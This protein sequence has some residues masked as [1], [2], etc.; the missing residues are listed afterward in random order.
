MNIITIENLQRIS[1]RQYADREFLPEAYSY[2]NEKL[3]DAYQNYHNLDVSDL[4]SFIYQSLQDYPYLGDIFTGL[5]KIGNSNYIISKIFEYIINIIMEN[6]RTIT[7]KIVTPFDVNTAITMNKFTALVIGI[8]KTIPVVVSLHNDITTI[9]MDYELYMGIIFGTFQSSDIKIMISKTV[10]NKNK[11]T[12]I[13]SLGNRYKVLLVEINRYMTFNN[14]SFIR[15]LNTAAKWQE[16]NSTS[17]WTNLKDNL[18]QTELIAT[19]CD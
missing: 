17:I 11:Y 9:Y 10:V 6:I 5:V 4:H 3:S 2:L 16:I 12:E 18:T 1:Q 13:T 8:F 7:T 15:G 19:F 14:C